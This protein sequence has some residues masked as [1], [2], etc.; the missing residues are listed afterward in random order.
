MSDIVF[1]SSEQVTVLCDNLKVQG[2]DL[3]LD[4]PARRRAQSH[5][6]RRAL[7]HDQNDGLTI[8]FNGDYPGGVTILGV[9]TLELSGE[10]RM[11]S[12]RVDFRTGRRFIE[13]L[14]LSDVLAS[15]R[16]EIAD[17]KAQVTALQQR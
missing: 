13:T 1:D 2:H 6:F 12:Q 3:L 17:L 5:G 11:K 7:V 10:M 14:V 15:M 9:E 16:Q 8:N 4:S